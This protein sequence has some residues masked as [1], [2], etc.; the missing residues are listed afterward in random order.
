MGRGR[1]PIDVSGFRKARLL[2]SSPYDG[3]GGDKVNKK[4]IHLSFPPP[5]APPTRGGEL[6]CRTVLNTLLGA[7]SDRQL[8]PPDAAE[9]SHAVAIVERCVECGGIAVHRDDLHVFRL[10]FSHL[11]ICKR[12]AKIKT[13]AA[14]TPRISNNF[15]KKYCRA[16]SHNLF[17]LQNLVLWTRIFTYRRPS[18]RLGSRPGKSEPTCLI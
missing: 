3:G 10:E 6:S 5:L 18:T 13:D 7:I 1:R 17:H 4:F 15:R 9:K 2:D 16:R 14:F 8:P 11:T 12:K